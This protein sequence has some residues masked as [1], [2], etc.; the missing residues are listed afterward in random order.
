MTSLSVSNPP[1]EGASWN[2]G[3]LVF[4]EVEILDFC[5]PFEVFAVTRLLDSNGK[6]TEKIPFNVKLISETGSKV[7]CRG[8]LKVVSDFSFMTS[9]GFDILVVPGGWGTRKEVNNSVLVEWIRN[10]WEK[11]QLMTSV[12]TGSFL[13]AKTGLLDG[14]EATT[15]WASL[16][17]LQ[18]SF[19][20]VKVI[21]NKRIVVTG[22]GKIV[23]SAGISS[24]IDMALYLVSN[25][26]GQE[27]AKNTAHY[28]EYRGNYAGI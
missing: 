14:L 10:Q 27:I 21:T 4:D 5:G 19:P 24:G 3:I 16:E 18:K 23:S 26:V 11:I 22:E 1:A 20:R 15:H 6:R 25:L 28:M 8:G 17:R 12:C 13:L 9:P 7:Q 2:V